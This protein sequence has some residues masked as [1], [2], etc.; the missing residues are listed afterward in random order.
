MKKINQAISKITKLPRWS[1]ILI[2][3][4][5]SAFAWFGYTQFNSSDSS[6]TYRSEKARQDTLKISITASGQVTSTNSTQITTQATGVVTKLYVQ[7]GTQVTKGQKI[8]QLELDLSGSQKSQSALAAYRNA[9]NNLSSA[10]STLYSLNSSMWSVNQK[11]INDAVA[12]DLATDDP[13]YIQ[14]NSDWLSAENKYKTQQSVISQA[15][16]SLNSAWLEYQQNS[17]FIYAPIT[18]RISGI[19]VQEGTIITSNSNQSTT[20]ANISTSGSPSISVNL[21]EIDI[22]QIELNQNATLTFDAY[23]NQIFNGQ[24][25]SINQVGVTSS[26]VT[27]YPVLISINDYDPQNIKL[28]PNMAANV[29]ITI[30]QIENTTLVPNSAVQTKGDKHYIRTLNLDGSLNQIPVKIGLSSTTDTQILEGINAG[31]SVVVGT[32]SNTTNSQTTSVFSSFGS[33]S[34]GGTRVPMR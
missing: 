13:T 9:Q 24:V 25:I 14:Q 20:I 12:R 7:D 11:L 6:P 17:N 8:A 1:K 22:P 31:D 23:P 29:E 30:N 19:L 4:I 15:Q 33:R 16:I 21:T 26:G 10:Q 27:S 3:I 18:G 5:I 34:T 32:I 28:L 2:L